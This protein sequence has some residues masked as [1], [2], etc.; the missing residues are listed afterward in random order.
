[1]LGV[2]KGMSQFK[3]ENFLSR[4]AEKLLREDFLVFFKLATFSALVLL[5][6]SS[7]WPFF[8]VTHFLGVHEIDSTFSSNSL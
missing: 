4:D 3:S 2:A 6:G 1:M 7:I 8:N 5:V